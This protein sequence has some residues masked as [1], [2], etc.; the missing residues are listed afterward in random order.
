MGIGRH[1]EDWNYTNDPLNS[2]VDRV[3]KLVG[4]T[5]ENAKLISDAEVEYNISVASDDYEAAY[6][7]AMDVLA[8]SS[9]FVNKTGGGQT[10]SAS[11]FY[12]HMEKLAA[13]LLARAPM[14]IPKAPQLRHDDRDRMRGDST[15]IQP[16]FGTAMLSE[17]GI[18]IR[19]NTNRIDPSEVLK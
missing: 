19:P 14:A 18:P 1:I 13:K 7:T 5:D 11:Q 2:Q 9:R 16:R 8:W 17:D 3:R 10:E 4:D 6:L 15:L 12:D